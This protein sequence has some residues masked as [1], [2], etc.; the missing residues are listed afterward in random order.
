[1]AILGVARDLELAIKKLIRLELR[2]TIGLVKEEI[3]E[4][5][6]IEKTVKKMVKKELANQKE[7]EVEEE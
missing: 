6:A 3:K 7:E 5:L 2:K 1:M 4:A